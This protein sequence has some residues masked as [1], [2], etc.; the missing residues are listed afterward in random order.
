MSEKDE[1]QQ[2]FEELFDEMAGDVEPAPVEMSIPDEGDEDVQLRTQEEEK[3]EERQ[4]T[5][6]PDTEPEPEPDPDVELTDADRIEKLQQETR[7]WKHRYNSDMGRQAA[8]QR[9]VKERDQQIA[10]LQKQLAS[11]QPAKPANPL[12]EDYPDI[13]EGADKLIQA[14]VA[15]LQNELQQMRN[16]VA[17]M[18]EQQN[19]KYIQGQYQTLADE[20]PDYEQIAAS[21]EFNAWVKEQP[22]FVQEKMES[23]EAHD[24]AWLL[25]SYKNE[26]ALATNNQGTSELKQRRKKQLR[27]AQN[28]P[29]RGGRSQQ[30]QPPESDFDA[31]FEYF[32]DLDERR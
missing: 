21:P 26:V 3:E 11:Q 6:E 12:S 15:P 22:H 24:A 18:Q 2:S 1:E 4:V 29:S 19:E 20:H 17:S 5:P 31:A 28:V 27:Q 14:Q 30:I 23:N 8:Y 10:Q 7:E 13:A 9:Q 25:R 32:A 16:F